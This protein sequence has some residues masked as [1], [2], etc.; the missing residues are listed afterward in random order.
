M[1]P[2]EVTALDAAISFSLYI[3]RQRRRA[4]EFLRST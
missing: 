4:S 3:G 1:T 2:N